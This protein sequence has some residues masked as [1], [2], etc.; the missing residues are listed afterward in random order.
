MWNM[1]LLEFVYFVIPFVENI[2][3]FFFYKSFNFLSP[4]IKH[5]SYIFQSA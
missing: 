5:E 1:F 2:R 4:F 3:I